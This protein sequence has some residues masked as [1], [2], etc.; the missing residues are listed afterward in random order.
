MENLEGKILTAVSGEHYTLSSII[1]EGAQGIV[2]NTENNQVVKL[3]KHE[4]DISDRNKLKKIDWLMKIDLPDQFIKPLDVF[5]E[6]YIG[7]AMKKVSRHISLNKLLIPDRN[8]PFHEWYNDK[9][10]GLNR[11]LYIAYKI[12]MQF[13]ELHKKNL[14]YCDISGNNILVNE[15]P[16]IVSVCMIDIDNIYIPG[17]DD[18]N[19]LGTSSYMAPEILKRQF[20][21]DT[22]TDIYSLAVI[23][24]E[25]LRSGHPYI[26]DMVED[27]SPDNMTEAYK[28]VY[29]Y[30]DDPDTDIN[31]SS[32]MLPAEAV[33]TTELQQL[34]AK[35]F[36]AGKENRLERT[37]AGEFA[38]ALLKARNLI[39]KCGHC[40]QWHYAKPD[41][42]R[43]YI[44]PWCDTEYENPMRLA[45]YNKYHFKPSAPVKDEHVYDYVLKKKNE[46]TNNYIKD[47]Y[48]ENAA[49][50]F[51]VYCKIETRPDGKLY[52]LNNNNNELFVQQNGRGKFIAVNKELE[53]NKGD[54]ILFCDISKVDYKQLDGHSQG[55]FF[56]YAVVK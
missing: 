51:D 56:R 6:P 30:V 22:F 43:K 44:C 55:V 53:I 23:L 24:F 42:E 14:A 35:T 16:R 39:V 28:G 5:K 37:S 1:G 36:V 13:A 20:N 9:T 8:L 3:Y 15:D 41:R 4:S 38:N 52:L 45:F 47:I 40:G 17:N 26:G 46:I 29:P 50:R 12:A 33:F 54:Y 10:G 18:I 11:R 21:P 32:Q 25:L 34:F 2:Y 7:Y 31:R 49:K 19:I 27:A 48:A